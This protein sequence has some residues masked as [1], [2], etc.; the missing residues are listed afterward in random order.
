[1]HA[2]HGMYS[3]VS[4]LLH[5]LCMYCAHG[6]IAAGPYCNASGCVCLTVGLQGDFVLAGLHALASLACALVQVF[7]SA[8]VCMSVRRAGLTSYHYQC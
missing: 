8:S 5:C 3:S 7:C 6:C 4:V 2:P 1:M